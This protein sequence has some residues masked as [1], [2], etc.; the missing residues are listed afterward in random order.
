MG[1]VARNITILVD[2]HR[3][4]EWSDRLYIGKVTNVICDVDVGAS[5]H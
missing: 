4:L 2:C 3:D 1:A 5:V